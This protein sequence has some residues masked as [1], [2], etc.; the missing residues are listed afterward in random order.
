MIKFYECNDFGQFQHEDG[1]S[2]PHFQVPSHFQF[3]QNCIK[4]KT[5]FFFTG[6][7][8]HWLLSRT[9]MSSNHFY[10][11]NLLAFDLDQIKNKQRIDFNPAHLTDM[12]KLFKGLPK[13]AFGIFF[14]GY[15]YHIYLFFDEYFY[16]EEYAES[17]SKVFE[18]PI[19]QALKPHN[20]KLD[21]KAFMPN[22]CLR[23]PNTP[24]LKLKT[25]DTVIGPYPTQII[26]H[27]TKEYSLS[28][29]IQHFAIKRDIKK[30]VL[31]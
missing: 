4:P 2:K 11:Q 28:Q 27:P 10:G 20:F 19:N 9:D 17:L 29:F 22:Q 14:T 12:L 21:Q 15:G 5:G 16:I 13:S 24:Y 30:K 23:L 7:S 3:W 1:K 6:K 8:F 18:K 26:L 31:K 25:K